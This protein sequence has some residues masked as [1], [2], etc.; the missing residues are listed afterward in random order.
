MFISFIGWLI[1]IGILQ[2]NHF[3]CFS[4]LTDDR[5]SIVAKTEIK[6]WKWKLRNLFIR[7]IQERCLKKMNG[8]FGKNYGDKNNLISLLG[9]NWGLDSKRKMIFP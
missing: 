6:V 7:R 3:L 1:I 4:L 2:M 5:N 9:L 8:A